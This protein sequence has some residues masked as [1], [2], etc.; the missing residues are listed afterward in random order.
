MKIF[1]TGGSGFIGRRLVDKLSK[2][3][4]N[5]IFCLTRD[6][7]KIQIS[8]EENIQYVEGDLIKPQTYEKFLQECDA[9]WYIPLVSQSTLSPICT[10]LFFEAV[11]AYNLYHETCS[12]VSI[13]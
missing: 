4:N 9:F 13:A 3:K 6:L 11:P 1:V 2:D 8:S 12:V 10:A 5:Q 7:T